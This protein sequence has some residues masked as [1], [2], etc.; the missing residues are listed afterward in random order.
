MNGEL[1]KCKCYDNKYDLNL[2]M[3]VPLQPFLFDKFD[4]N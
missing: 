3:Y 1:E 2:H 4:K